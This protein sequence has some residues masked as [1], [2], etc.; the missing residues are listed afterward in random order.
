[1]SRTMTERSDGRRL[2]QE[3]SDLMCSALV[4]THDFAVRA[5]AVL[6]LLAY[7]LTYG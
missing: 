4:S 6:K 1:M 5:L 7:A 3:P 2:R